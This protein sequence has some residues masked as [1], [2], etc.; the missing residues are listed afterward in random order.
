MKKP[1]LIDGARVLRRLYAL[2]GALTRLRNE[3]AYP[4]PMYPRAM[5]YSLNN[6]IGIVREE[7]ERSEKDD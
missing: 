3:G 2:R 1:T 6:A 4:N 5:R 7:M